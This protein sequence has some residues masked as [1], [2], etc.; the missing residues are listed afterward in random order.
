MS[1]VFNLVRL[2]VLY[3]PSVTRSIHSLHVK[4]VTVLEVYS[5]YNQLYIL[6]SHACMFNN[7]N[8]Y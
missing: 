4:K 3:I 6:Y 1:I 7:K 5:N 2:T 8:K